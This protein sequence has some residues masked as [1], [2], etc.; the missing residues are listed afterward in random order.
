MMYFP[1][2]VFYWNPVQPH[3]DEADDMLLWVTDVS[4]ANAAL[5]A[6]FFSACQTAI[7]GNIYVSS[8]IVQAVRN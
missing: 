2:K 4:S 3:S 7:L 5:L 6:L 1:N 8:N